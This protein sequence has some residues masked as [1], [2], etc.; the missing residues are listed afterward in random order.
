[1]PAAFL[2]SIAFLTSVA[3]S[4][5]RCFKGAVHVHSGRSFDSKGTFEEIETAAQ[6]AGLD[7]VVLTDHQPSRKD[8]S[9]KKM[10]LLPKTKTLWIDGA[11]VAPDKKHDF[12]VLGG[13]ATNIQWEQGREM[14]GIKQA[15]EKGAVIFLGHLARARPFDHLELA[16]GVEIFNPHKS[17]AGF[18]AQIPR[19]THI[20][21]SHRKNLDVLW[22]SLL[23]PPRKEI[24]VWHRLAREKNLGILAGNDAHQNIRIFGSLL[25]PYEQNFRFV[26]TYVWAA[27]LTE[28]S[29]LNALKTGASYVGFPIIEEAAGFRFKSSGGRLVADLPAGTTGEIRLFKDNRLVTVRDNASSVSYETREPGLYRVEVWRRVRRKNRPWIYSNL[30]RVP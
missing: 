14:E 23:D 25:D 8:Q 21:I 16:D 6:K 20:L 5:D 19:F 7:F 9:V 13:G 4:E 18:L 30:L 17:A 1:M 22:L 2:A 10:A 27:K 15:K 3:F 24:T 29:I 11:E 26:N 28:E 12:L